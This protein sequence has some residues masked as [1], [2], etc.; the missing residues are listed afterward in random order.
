LAYTR[1]GE[2]E[3]PQT[4]A[5]KPN[6][7]PVSSVDP[8]LHAGVGAVLRGAHDIVAQFEGSDRPSLA[9][10]IETCQETLLS[11]QDPA[12]IAAA[13]SRGGELTLQA[14][15][16]VAAQR[17]AERQETASLI[18]AIQGAVAALSGENEAFHA[19]LKQSTDRFDRIAGIN[20]IIELKTRLM[21]EVS[22]L[23][24]K[25]AEGQR[26][27]Q[28]SVEALGRRIASLELQLHTTRQ[29]G[30]LD[31]LTGAANRG[32]FDKRCQEWLKSGLL[33]FSIL[34]IDVDDFK[35]VNDTFGHPEGDRV[36]VAVAEALMT[37][38][39]SSQ[40]MVARI[41]GDEF[42]VLAL[43]LPL[44]GAENLFARFC[45]SLQKSSQAEKP[46]IA[47]VSLSGGV[48]EFS[49]GDTVK[50]LVQRADDALYEAKRMG[51]NRVVIKE[52]PLIRDL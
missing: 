11:S 22:V 40:D 25:T 4:Q 21:A 28:S 35:K 24:V 31:P 36:L 52:K 6:P 19:S 32:A 20:H 13:A 17:N 29:E 18:E 42:A 48:A 44:R 9:Q 12:A 50:S 10:Q 2:Y 8:V 15:A 3:E 27:W 14:A 1:L 45:A 7:E 26:A 39:R 51:K 47:P 43:D 49:A 41:G 33:Q 23:K 46:P 37:T 30:A 34:L 38:V 5:P 16:F